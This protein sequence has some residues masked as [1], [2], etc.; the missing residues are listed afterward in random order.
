LAESGI[1]VK[2]KAK[3]KVSVAREKTMEFVEQPLSYEEARKAVLTFEHAHKT[4]SEAVFSGKC[5]PHLHISP[6]ALFE[7]K[8]YYEFVCD[9][10]RQ[11]AA[12]LSEKPRLEDVRYSHSGHGAHPRTSE[13]RKQASLCVAA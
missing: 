11:F 4:I 9:Y 1:M 10:E 3:S 2:K 13:Q 6:D 5:E 8:S 12:A 7:W